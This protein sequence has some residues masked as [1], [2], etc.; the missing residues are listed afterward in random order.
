[1]ANRDGGKAGWLPSAATALAIASCYGTAA[2]ATLLSLLGISISIDARA[3]AVV[4]TLFAALAAVAIAVAYRRHRKIGPLALAGLG[5]A[6]I[7]W[8]MYGSYSWILELAGFVLLAAAT[9]WNWRAR[10]SHQGVGTDGSW[11][12]AEGLAAQLQEEPKPIIVDVRQPDEF[13]GELGH[14]PGARNLPL[15]ALPHRSAELSSFMERQVVLVCRTQMRS[16]K[17]ASILEDAGFTNVAVLRGGMVEWARRRF[18]IEGGTAR[19]P[20]QEKGQ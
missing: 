15:G 20:T 13:A 5:L 11:V 14:L 16:A 7:L 17:A 12:E 19:S 3:S 4:I 8:V 10:A 6:L 18:P 1:M 9:A 2:A